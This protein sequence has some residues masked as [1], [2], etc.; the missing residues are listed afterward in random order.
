MSRQ[1]LVTSA[2]DPLERGQFTDGHSRFNV[3]A[4]SA[5]A[6]D[7]FQVYANSN[8]ADLVL[9]VSGLISGNLH[10]TWGQG[11]RTFAPEWK[12]WL[13]D[14]AFTVFYNGTQINQRPGKVRFCEG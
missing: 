5:Q 1:N 13:E 7:S 12:I 10:A 2:A 8:H 9:I 4:S 14:T 11:W 6:P 3:R